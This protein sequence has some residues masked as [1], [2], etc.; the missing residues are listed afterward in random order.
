MSIYKDIYFYQQQVQSKV[1]DVKLRHTISE[2][3]TSQQMG[4]ESKFLPLLSISSVD[5]GPRIK[6][7]LFTS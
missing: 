5:I 1:E 3:R 6:V 4:E 2:L 7:D